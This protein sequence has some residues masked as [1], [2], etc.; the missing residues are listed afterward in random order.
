MIKTYKLLDCCKIRLKG[1]D[2][3]RFLSVCASLEVNFYDID[4]Q[5]A[6]SSE[7]LAAYVKRGDLEKLKEAA[8]KTAVRFDIEKEFGVIS[9]LRHYISRKVFFLSLTAATLFLYILTLFIWRIDISGCVNRSE[10]EIMAVIASCDISYGMFK[11]KCD[12]EKIEEAIRNT[13][14]DVLWVSASINGT[15]LFV[16]IKENTYLNDK[17]AL[18]EGTADLVADRNGKVVSIVTRT[19]V[20]AVKEGDEVTEGTI[21]ISGAEDYL[22]DAQEVYR[23]NLVYADGDVIV[24]SAENYDWNYP[25]TIKVKKF[26]GKKKHG[27]RI[28]LFDKKL[29][30]YEPKVNNDHY[31]FRSAE[32]ILVIGESFYLPVNIR[33]SL[34]KMYETEEYRLSDEALQT[35]A[36]I[37]YKMF[38]IKQKSKGVDIIEKNATIRFSESGCTVHASMLTRS[39]CG[40]SAPTSD[41]MPVE[42]LGES[43]DT[44]Y[45]EET[46][47]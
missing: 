27:I 13:Y 19:G 44:Y 46:N 23:T 9:F 45:T 17:L 41:D 35:Y 28:T 31:D 10:E 12:C 21:L 5:A 26:T 18:H 3:I 22:N 32:N 16:Q 14:D 36:G 25:R 43:G 42:P 30:N 38:C 11:N 1:T 8:D 40:V 15:G 4:L 39:R 2:F 20:P 24:E 47:D 29:I 7:P 34:Y 37:L 33:Q 6:E